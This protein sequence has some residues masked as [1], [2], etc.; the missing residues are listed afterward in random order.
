MSP[1]GC[2]WRDLKLRGEGVVETHYTW[3]TIFC[4]I[5]R[6]LL[7]RLDKLWLLWGKK[8]LRSK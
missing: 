1:S 2:N 7:V 8:S 5:Y 4:L 6:I 3:T